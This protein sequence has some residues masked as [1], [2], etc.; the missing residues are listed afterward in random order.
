MVDGK[1]FL[2]HRAMREAQRQQVMVRVSEILNN[3]K[4]IQV[5]Q[6]PPQ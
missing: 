6:E 2:Q 4:A 5:N 1:I 3:K